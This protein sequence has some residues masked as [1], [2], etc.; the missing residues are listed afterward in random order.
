[1]SR[2]APSRLKVLYAGPLGPH[3]LCLIRCLALEDLG[4]EVVRF[5]FA[6][7]HEVLYGTLPIRAARK[8]WPSRFLGPI[9]RAFAEAVEQARPD[10]VYVDKGIHFTER[11]MQRL[12]KVRA[13]SGVRPVLLHFHPDDAFG[14]ALYS[15]LY[16]QTVPYYDCHFIPHRWVLDQH[17]AHGAKRAEFW[18]FG[19]YPKIHAPV[20]VAEAPAADLA[21]DV[22]F[23][24][25]WEKGRAG[26]LEALA[27][28][29][30]QAGVWGTD[31]EKLPADSALRPFV[32]W[33]SAI[34]K[35]LAAIASLSKISLGFLSVTNHNGHTSRTFEIPASGGF[36]L[37]ARS[38]GQKEFF[39]EGT[40]IECFGSYEEMR[41]KIRWYLS[42]D[43]ARERIRKAG[44]D[45]SLRSGYSYHDRF[46]FVLEVAA[47]CRE[48]IG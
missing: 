45:R 41:D 7:F 5:D 25:R 46:R 18:P 33:R 34:G 42:H 21:V 29:G 2:T 28:E 19:F 44:R 8:L 39:E 23:V 32:R 4:P 36:M 43:E 48:A 1:M 40:E 9:N 37:A 15:D 47:Q 20:P 38:D 24:G 13:P 31:W 6:P 10:I 11:T 35:E 12:L 22:A 26:E 27:R 16:K 14:P 17:R 30:V 3:E